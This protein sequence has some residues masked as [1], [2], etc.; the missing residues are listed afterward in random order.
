MED[1]II[2]SLTVIILTY[3][4]EKN[5]ALTLTSI[6]DRF[7]NVLV[8]DSYST[9]NT[10]GVI[11]QNFDSIEV[12]QNEFES[13][14][15]QRIWAVENEPF[16]SEWVFFL[17]AD[18]IVTELLF[19]EISGLNFDYMGYYLFYE[20]YF[21]EKRIKYG[22]YSRNY[23]LRIFNKSDYEISREMNEHIFISGQTKKLRNPFVHKDNNGFAFWLRKHVDY[24][25]R[26]ANELLKPSSFGD[27][28]LFGNQV[29][30]KRWLRD[31][32]WNR[33]P[34]LV[35]P[36]LYFIYRYIFR[37]GFLDG[38]RGLVFHFFHAFVYYLIIDIIFIEKKYVRSNRVS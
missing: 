4:E 22:G 3:N 7:P 28:D 19:K 26:E 1:K 31:Y 34:P 18:E 9:D 17:D 33:L 14:R 16:G 6:I 30:R 38:L 2:N 25:K 11:S 24:A 36:I 12:R 13:Y 37:L 20:F 29:E 15:K 32:I 5:I 27:G 10:L 21:L 8:V 35:R 23:I